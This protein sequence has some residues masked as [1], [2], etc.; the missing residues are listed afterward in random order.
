MRAFSRSV[1]DS[2]TAVRR[3]APAGDGEG[4]TATTGRV[5]GC[6]GVEIARPEKDILHKSRL[7]SRLHTA[8][9]QQCH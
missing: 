8:S 9:C 7:Y 4:Y 6:G 2:T 5:G 3:V 1:G